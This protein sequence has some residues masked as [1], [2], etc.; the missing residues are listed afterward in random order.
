MRAGKLTI[1]DENGKVMSGNEKMEIKVTNTD[2]TTRLGAGMNQRTK[3]Y[4]E[5]PIP[6]DVTDSNSVTWGEDRMNALELAALNVSQ[7]AMAGS[8]VDGMVELGRTAVDA[9]NNGIVITRIR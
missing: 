5:L 4:I 3:F 6:Q 8:P 2:A 9:L 7:N 1:K